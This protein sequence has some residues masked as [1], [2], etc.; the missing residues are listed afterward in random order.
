LPSV[1]RSILPSVDPPPALAAASSVGEAWAAA[2][3]TAGLTEEAMAIH[4]AAHYG[5]GVAKFA[6]AHATAVKLLPPSVVRQYE[7]YPLREDNRNLFVATSA[8]M[9]LD[10]EQAVRFA[11]G[12][13]PVMEVATPS[14]LHQA[15][16]HAYSSDRAVESILEHV[17]AD[18]E[19]LVQVVDDTG[20][21]TVTT[22]EAE[23]SPIIKLSNLLLRD[24]VKQGASDVHIQPGPGAGIVRFRVDGLLRRYMQLPMPVLDRVVSRIKV[25]G[26]LDITNRLKPQDG[27]TT[28]SVGDRRID[29]RVSTIPTR[30]SEK[31]VLRLLDPVG[32][33]GLESVGIPRPEMEQLRRLLEH[34]EG[35][36]VVTG[37]TGSGKTT[38][39]YACLRELA[40]EDV[41]IMT[42]EDP[43]EYELKG[44]T[45]V[46]V[47]PR[48][49][50][51]FASA[52]RAILRQDPDIIFVGEIR[53]LE[54]A[55]TAVQASLT[56]H[57]VL[58][59]LHTNNAVGAVRRLIDLGLTPSAVADTLR[60]AAA[61]RLVRRLCPACATT[62]DDPLTAEE[63]GLQAAYGLRP[64]RRATGCD[65]CGLMGFSGRLPV[66]ELVRIHPELQALIRRDAASAEL[67]AAAVASGMRPLQ[68]VALEFVERHETTLAEVQRILGDPT[69]S[70]GDGGDVV[71]DEAL[72]PGAAA[73][74]RLTGSSTQ[75][76][77]G[78]S[79]NDHPADPRHVLVVDD[80]ATNRL[81]AR[82]LLE[83]EGLRVTEATDGLVALERLGT[84]EYDLMILDLDMPRLAGYEVLSHVRR[85]VST[86]TLPVIVLT[87]T[88]NENAEIE[89]MERGA[90]D[91]LSKPIDA[92][93]FMARV[94]AALRRAAG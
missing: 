55:Q 21:A 65:A 25:L 12:R 17:D 6:A 37:P 89:V 91:Y 4:I 83:H 10:A 52:L 15:I 24:A 66:V 29:L 69:G 18:I 57:L 38:T 86:S 61:Q 81:F 32:S 54:T 90:D 68:T 92:R 8:P 5:L 67:Q 44:M 9:D 46:Q 27:R 74:H 85:Q 13:T 43:I 26:K 23:R 30:D 73:P 7:V 49:G 87:G 75:P 63:T 14:A 62:A 34:R 3:R 64:S 41:N 71:E 59:T 60:G 72:S 78:A 79:G 1:L 31:A 50:V 70:A 22:A 56:G 53:D 2:C 35:M 51:T 42:V 40:T 82:A 33:G 76:A 48:Q 19:T 47:E 58:A 16:E 84:D 93:R 36:V 20:P 11:S 39:L 88:S 28:I 77:P 45:Q 80:D 94:K